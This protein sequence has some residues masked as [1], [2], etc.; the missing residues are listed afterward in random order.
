MPPPPIR[1]SRTLEYLEE[2]SA[3]PVQFLRDLLRAQPPVKTKHGMGDIFEQV[4]E[5]R[6]ESM[7]LFGKKRQVRRVFVESYDTKDYLG[8]GW[9]VKEDMEFCMVCSR[10]F[11]ILSI[12]D[13]QTNCRACGNIVCSRC[14][15]TNTVRQLKVRWCALPLVRPPPS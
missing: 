8:V 14:L 5:L 1:V 13:P 4:T 10:P 15:D 11:G 6:V 3:K 7:V 9:V 12:F 2:M